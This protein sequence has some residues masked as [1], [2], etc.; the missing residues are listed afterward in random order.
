MRLP[1]LLLVSLTLAACDRGAA[2]ATPATPATPAVSAALPALVV[3]DVWVREPTPPAPVAGGY[4]T[5]TNPGPQD[6]RLQAV[7][8]MAAE[9]VEIHEMRMNDG[10]MQMR[11]LTDGLLIPAGETVTLAP[12]GIHLMLIAPSPGLTAGTSV[13]LTLQFA[14]GPAQT[15]TAEVRGSATRPSDD[16]GHAHG[17]HAD[18]DHDHGG[19]GEHTH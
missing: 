8:T 9:R 17:D 19:E 5:L 3:T 4:L 13:P 18:A 14:D 2:P 11:P 10:M 15:V 7:A 1:L 12:G 16:A 6:R